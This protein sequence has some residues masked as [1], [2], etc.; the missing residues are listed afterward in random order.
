MYLLCW[1]C[2]RARTT[3]YGYV[4]TTAN[5]L[6]NAAIV[7]YSKAFCLHRQTERERERKKWAEPSGKNDES[8]LQLLVIN[9]GLSLIRLKS[10]KPHAWV[11]L[12][13]EHVS[14]LSVAHGVNDSP[15]LYLRALFCICCSLSSVLHRPWT[16]ALHE[17]C[18]KVQE[19]NPLKCINSVSQSVLI[20]W[21]ISM[22]N[23]SIEKPTTLCLKLPA[24]CQVD[25]E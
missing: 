22:N 3:W 21:K 23:V 24:F 25:T 14:S 4:V 19:H 17:M 8:L 9:C 13:T 20:C 1:S 7:I 11:S 15:A 6:D 2:R 10:Y 16:A 12:N 5:I 18:Q